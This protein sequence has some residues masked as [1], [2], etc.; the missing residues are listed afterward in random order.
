MKTKN[1]IVQACENGNY[2]QK[3]VGLFIFFFFWMK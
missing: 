2:E 1:K 3:F